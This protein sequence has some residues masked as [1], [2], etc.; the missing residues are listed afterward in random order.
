MK[1]SNFILRLLKNF[2]RIFSLNDR[3][4]IAFFSTLLLIG[5][6]LEIF[7]LILVYPLINLFIDP[8]YSIDFSNITLDTS[9]I[10]LFNDRFYFSTFV[11]T[12]FIIK[13]VYT[14][15]LN[16]ALNNFLTKFVL[17]IN[18]KLF[19]KYLNVPYLKFIEKKKSEIVQLIQTESY[20]FFH[21][22]RGIMF[23][24]KDSAYFIIIY[25]FLLLTELKGTLSLTLTLSILYGIFYSF[26]MNK[27][28]SWGRLRTKSDLSLSN[29]LLETLGLFININMLNK[30]QFYENV[31][32]Q[33]SQIKSKVW[34]NQ[35]TFE[36]LPRHFI[37]ITLIIGLS[38][39]V[40][41]L[42]YFENNITYIISITGVLVAAS[43]KLIPAIN[44]IFASVQSIRYYK[45]SV[46]LILEEIEEKVNYNQDKIN[47]LKFENT[48]EIKE[49][50]YKYNDK[51]E[52][53][54]ENISFKFNKGDFIGIIGESGSGKTTLINIISGL[55][56]LNKGEILVDDISILNNTKGWQN[57][58]GYVGQ[59]TYLINNSI[60]K[61]IAIGLPDD[62]ID[63]LRVRD[64]IKIVKLEK[65]VEDL[66]NGIES[67]VGEEGIKVSGGQKQRLGIARALYNKPSLIIFDESTNSLDKETE[68]K[69]LNDVIGMKGS[70]SLIF[71]SHDVNTLRICDTIYKLDKGSLKYNL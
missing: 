13:T 42:F 15:Y 25:A 2:N 7:S 47:E 68:N 11:I 23:I 35:L 16:K 59:S 44:T 5:G 14:V 8:N 56:P 57:K 34:S 36:Q 31:F 67:F 66:D 55:I 9:L 30:N 49:I 69:L 53:I 17:D 64:C 4:R 43:L 58:I 6:F 28:I 21:F 19:R 45:H 33:E 37:E 10:N 29:L 65:F 12:I 51:D 63:E 60:K 62:Q 22:T 24:L 40:A 41:A 32:V 3:K 54:L 46:K 18:Y 61:N 20:S 50:S 48:I 1:N 39:F 38:S 70:V 27:N 52:N 26:I 71:I